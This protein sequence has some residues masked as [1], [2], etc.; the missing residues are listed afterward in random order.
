MTP[1]K[2]SLQEEQGI[3]TH[4]VAD[5]AHRKAG[6]PDPEVRYPETKFVRC[7][8]HEGD[9]CPRCSGS[10][11]RPRARCTS[12][13]VTAGRPSQGDKALS[14]ERGAKSWEE[15]RSLPLYCMDCNPRFL[16]TGLALFEETGS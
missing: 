8:T 9:D 13:S 3:S 16:R 10:G 15:L 1:L 2:T 7:F 5:L 6:I 4:L 11:F 14:P 12:C